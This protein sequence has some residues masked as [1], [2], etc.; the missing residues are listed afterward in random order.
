ME[1][2]E[3]CNTVLNNL[4]AE[5]TNLCNAYVKFINKKIEE[6]LEQSDIREKLAEAIAKGLPYYIDENLNIKML[7]E[8]LRQ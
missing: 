2:V 3:L 8:E 4:S 1:Y 6:Q 7:T 5:E